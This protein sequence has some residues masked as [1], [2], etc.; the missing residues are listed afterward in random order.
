MTGMRSYNHVG[1]A[2]SVLLEFDTRAIA[3]LR[4]DQYVVFSVAPGTHFLAVKD[5]DAVRFEAEPGDEL[6]FRLWF[7]E[8]WRLKQ[9][10]ADQAID[11]L[12]RGDYEHITWS[13]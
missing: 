6:Y 7:D 2:M 5:L 11:R 8:S 4:V 13:K 12:E 9:V 1:A 10:R 3:Y